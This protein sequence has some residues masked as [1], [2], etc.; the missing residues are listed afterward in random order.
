MPSVV[1]KPYDPLVETSLLKMIKLVSIFYITLHFNIT[2]FLR[3]YNIATY[4]S[5]FY[6]LIEEPSLN[7]LLVFCILFYII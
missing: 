4:F 2:G 5:Y 6:M 1:F 3:C 7:L